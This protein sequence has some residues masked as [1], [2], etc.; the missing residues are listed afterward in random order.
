MVDT[1]ERGR[2]RNRRI[3]GGKSQVNSIKN[4]YIMGYIKER[5]YLNKVWIQYKRDVDKT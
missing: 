4:R 1:I 5:G 3:S 2:K